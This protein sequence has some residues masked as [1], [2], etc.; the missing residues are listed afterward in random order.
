MGNRF[1]GTGRGFAR[2]ARRETQ[3]LAIQPATATVDNSSVLV[4][5]LNAAALALRPFT[6]VRMHME[7]Y[8]F[9][10]QV[11]ATESF[12]G[13]VGQCVVSESAAAA[14][15]VSIPTPITELDSDL[16][17]LHRFL[18]GGFTF[19]DATGFASVDGYRTSIDSKAM[20]KVNNDEQLALVV[21]GDSLGDGVTIIM[22]GRLLLKLH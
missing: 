9:S 1:R 8:Y 5:T 7:V 12:V 13:A 16:W 17:M 10:D 4:S 19:A 18:I 2:G 11:I 21:Q 3:W 20:R 15:V 6:I 14:G 22:A